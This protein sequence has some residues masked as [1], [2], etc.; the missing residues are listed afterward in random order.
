MSAKI[1]WLTGLSGSGKTT[2]SQI[3]LKKLLKKKYKVK[4]IDGDI[5]RKKKKNNSF[6]KKNIIV[7]NLSIIKYIKKIEKKF[8]YIIVTVISPLLKTR[9]Y[10]KK[11]FKEKYFEVLVSCNLKTL[12][13]RDTKGLYRKAKNKEIKNLIGY[14]SK[15]KYER[16]NYEKIIV[17]TNIY[18]IS[19]CV[20]K[21]MNKIV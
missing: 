1:I 10:A 16:S 6:S 19:H 21:I 8:D 13:L 12:E 14:N 2:L 18:T 11:S 20:K 3:I 15:I 5:F 9:I 17:K 4:N 7:N